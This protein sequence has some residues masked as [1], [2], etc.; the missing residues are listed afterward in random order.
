MERE[1]K[2]ILDT[3]SAQGASYADMRIVERQMESIVVKNSRLDRNT[4]SQNRGFGIRVLFDG[5]WGFACSFEQTPEEFVRVAEEAL[6]MARGAAKLGK[7]KVKL[8]PVKAARGSWKSPC[9]VNPLHV[10]KEQKVE[11]LFA[12]CKEMEIPGVLVAR[13]SFDFFVEKKL[14]ASTEGSYTDQEIVISGAGIEAT[15]LEG[16]E[17][18]NRSYPNSFGGNYVQAG[19]EYIERLD[20]VKHA[21]K[22]AEEAV[23]LLKA[24]QAPS[25]QKTVILDS[26]QVGLQIHESCGHPTELDRVLGMELGFAGGSFLSPDKKGK[27]RYGSDKITIVADAT[28]PEGIGTFAFD[29][30]GVPAQVTTLIDH[31]NFVGYLSSRE[32]AAQF[33][34][35]SNGTMRGDGWN[36]L[37]LIRMTN[38]NLNPGDWS[39]DEMIKE[40]ED[41]LLMVTNRSWSIDDQRLNF[42][43]G[44]EMAYEIKNGSLG[45]LYK[46]ATYTGI[47]PEFWGSCDAVA[48]KKFWELW[49]LPNCGKGEPVQTMF[50]GHGASPARYRNVRVGVGKW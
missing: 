29:D 28:C 37:P 27:F 34:E 18:Q 38:I 8:A 2:K 21:R 19:Y 5:A 30:E 45:K 13:A 1:M 24:P 17:N 14:F 9:K 41:G 42:Q 31:G 43:F 20:L 7:E 10:K 40:T 15:A 16:D 22:I 49:G 35:E 44:T 33:G 3:L 36:S 47:T 50:V 25:G 46:N 11:L 6:K 39:L 32:T 12:A 48:S 26:S 4:E 23:A